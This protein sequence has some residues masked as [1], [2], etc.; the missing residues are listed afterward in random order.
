MNSR[1]YSICGLLRHASCGALGMLLLFSIETSGFAADRIPVSTPDSNLLLTGIILDG[2]NSLAI[3]N[4]HSRSDDAYRVGDH[5]MPDAIVTSIKVDHVNVRIAGRNYV[6]T[7]GG[8]NHDPGALP[9]GDKPPVRAIPAYAHAF[10]VPMPGITFISDN[11]FIITRKKFRS[12]LYSPDALR[13]ARWL[14]EPKEGVFIE[15]LRDES[16]FVKAGLRTGDVITQINGHSIKSAEDAMKIYSGFANL[17]HLDIQITRMG[18]QQH[19]LY[20]IKE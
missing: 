7:L 4:V 5:V 12:F 8:M 16:P 6:L 18:Q 1:G 20:D 2:N 3:I 19:L 17:N 11:H 10:D 13:D 14:L 9:A 15:R